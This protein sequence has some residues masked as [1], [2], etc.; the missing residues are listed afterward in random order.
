MFKLLPS[1]CGLSRPYCHH[2][3]QPGLLPHPVP[4]AGMVSGFSEGRKESPNH[5]KLK[6][7]MGEA[8]WVALRCQK[9]KEEP[10]LAQALNATSPANSLSQYHDPCCLTPAL[11]LNPWLPVPLWPCPGPQCSV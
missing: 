10:I 1:A 9:E 6:S 5:L 3:A 2:K 4:Q 8:Q 7:H 11:W